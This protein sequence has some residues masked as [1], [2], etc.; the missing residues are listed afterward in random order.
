MRG[1][2]RSAI[3]LPRTI[4]T[5]VSVRPDVALIAP[6]PPRDERHGGHSGVA[7]YTANLAH[8]LARSGSDPAEARR[9]ADELS[10]KGTKDEELADIR[11]LVGSHKP[12]SKKTK[13]KVKVSR[14]NA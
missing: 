14:P 12:S 13:K 3:F 7:S 10:Q 4:S 9:I 5:V 11:E 6:Y 8:A 2:R 1:W